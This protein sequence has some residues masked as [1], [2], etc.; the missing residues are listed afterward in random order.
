LLFGAC[1]NCVLW[2]PT[3]PGEF[4][5]ERRVR[6]EYTIRDGKIVRYEATMLEGESG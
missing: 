2:L 6:I 3:L 1:Q 4:A 5:Y